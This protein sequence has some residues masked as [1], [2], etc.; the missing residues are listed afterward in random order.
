ML[1]VTFAVSTGKVAWLAVS[2]SPVACPTVLAVSAVPVA[3]PAVMA[4]ST[5]PV[6]VAAVAT[7]PV[8]VPVL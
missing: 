4:V 6:A 3:C 2:T 8:Q 7:L 1:K 5:V